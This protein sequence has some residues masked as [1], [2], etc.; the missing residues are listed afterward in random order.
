M[1]K[2]AKRFK[3]YLKEVIHSGDCDGRNYN[4]RFSNCGDGGV[5]GIRDSRLE[6]KED[7]N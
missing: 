6:L 5:L 4:S 7:I 1:A 3:E 2:I